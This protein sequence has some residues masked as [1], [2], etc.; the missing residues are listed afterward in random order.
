MKHTARE[1]EYLID[2]FV[3]K[4]KDE[5]SPFLKQAFDTSYQTIVDIFELKSGLKQISG[6]EQAEVKKSPK[7]KYL[8][9]KFRRDM[10]SLVE[11]LGKCDCHFIRCIKPNEFKRSDFWNPHLALMQIQ[12]MGMLDSLKVRKQSYPFRFFYS[13][14]FEIY[15]DLDMGENG[16]KNF[17]SLEEEGAN[18]R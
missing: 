5:L 12:Y 1:V 15:Q 16:S 3:E 7:E 9:F 17:R 6:Q 2:G 10:S 14:F 18:F 4:N 11:Q 8:G 13:K